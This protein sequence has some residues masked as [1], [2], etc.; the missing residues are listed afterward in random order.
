MLLT[1]FDA[2]EHDRHTYADGREDGLAEGLTKGLSKGMIEGRILA[3][4]DMH[5]S[6]EKI[7]EK[8]GQ[9]LDVVLKII[10]KE[11]YDTK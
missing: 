2:K 7:S 5:L 8:T 3:Y 4:H 1:E 10:E 6:L 9:P 11:S